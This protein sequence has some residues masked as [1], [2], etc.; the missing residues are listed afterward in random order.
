MGELRYLMPWLVMLCHVTL[1]LI[2]PKGK[3]FTAANGDKAKEQKY[4]ES[5]G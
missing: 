2:D 1:I 4:V 3:F 5:G